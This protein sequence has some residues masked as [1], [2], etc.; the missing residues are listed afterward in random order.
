MPYRC[1]INQVVCH[2]PRVSQGSDTICMAPVFRVINWV[3]RTRSLPEASLLLNRPLP[4]CDGFL[5]QPAP[6]GHC[7]S[8]SDADGCAHS[9]VTTP[10][11]LKLCPVRVGTVWSAELVWQHPRKSSRMSMAVSRDFSLVLLWEFW[12][13]VIKRQANIDLRLGPQVCHP[14]ARL[15][16]EIPL[17]RFCSAWLQKHFSMLQHLWCQNWKQANISFHL[18]P[19]AM[20]N[21]SCRVDK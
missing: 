14:L 11:L 19:P 12:K 16:K 13:P 10:P 2:V 21:I 9:S 1:D 20:W 15:G 5:Q 6:E 8:S 4:A 3:C 7:F 17:N 18:F